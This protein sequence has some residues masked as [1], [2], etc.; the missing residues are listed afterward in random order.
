MKKL[1]VWLALFLIPVAFLRAQDV[2]V[3]TN[4]LYDATTTLNLGV[5]IGLAEK[6]TL[7]VSGNYNPWE[8]SNNRQL[9]HALLQPEARY[10]FCEKFNRHFVGVHLHGA[11]YNAGRLKLPFHIGD[12]GIRENRYKGWLVGAGV[13]YGYHWIIDRRW[14]V[15]ATIG[16]GYAYLGYDKYR[17]CEHCKEKR[18]HESDHYFGPTK[19]ALS[20]IYIIK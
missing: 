3:K 1:I 18:G 5:E 2:A 19:A 10:W 8:F 11:I 17:I 9:K 14:S 4:L 20:I 6:W 13:S 15:E 16:V 12:E 7:D